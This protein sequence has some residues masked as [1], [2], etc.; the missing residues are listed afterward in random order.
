MKIIL[1][2]V[3]TADGKVSAENA[4]PA[5]WSSREDKEHFRN[6]T[7]KVGIVI[8]GRITY[9]TLKKPLPNRLNIIL[10]GNPE[11]FADVP[12]KV[13]FYNKSPGEL[14]KI[15]E[16]RRFTSAVLIGGPATNAR[17]LNES[18][19]DEIILTQ[20]AILFGKGSGFCEGLKKRINLE[21]TDIKKLSPKTLIIHYKV[22][23]H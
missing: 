14:V 5:N 21:I 2:M 8:M 7:K 4:N 16:S 12:G 17:F 13:E 19:V 3:Q 15:L 20:E 11:R 18:L 10:T 22:V 6:F 23:A 9:E 1:M